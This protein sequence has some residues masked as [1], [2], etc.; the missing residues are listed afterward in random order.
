MYRRADR[1]YYDLSLCPVSGCTA[2]FE[3]SI[4]LDAHIAA[5][6][7]IVPDSTPRTA[8]DIARIHLTEVLRSTRSQTRA[9]AILKQQVAST[10]DL[11]NSFHNRF[12]SNNGWALRKRKLGKPMGEKVKTFI[13]QI[14][15]DSLQTNSRITP[16]NIQEKMRAKRDSTGIK[17]FQTHEYPTKNQIMYQFRNLQRKYDV[18]RKQQL[19]VE[20]IDEHIDS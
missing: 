5:N 14:W 17:F 1:Q 19:I 20:I 8:N 15:L 18:T 2:A 6:L 3:S 11:S 16:E 10:Y 13:E 7:H 12:L 4:E 9:Q